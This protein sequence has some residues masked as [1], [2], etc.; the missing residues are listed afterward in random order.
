[1]A[2]VSPVSGSGGGAVPLPPA[3]V[4]SAG[5]SGTPASNAGQCGGATSTTGA[6]Q[7]QNA[8]SLTPAG[9]TQQSGQTGYA[10]SITSSSYSI[11]QSGQDNRLSALV[12]ALVHY[13]LTGKEDEKEKNN[14]FAAL[15]GMALLSSLDQQTG[16]VS[17]YESHSS[18]YSQS[19]STSNASAVQAASYDQASGTATSGPATGGSLDVCG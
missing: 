7:S 8:V 15:I 5:A 4:T 12:M 1:M 19:V 3:N 10:Q 14:P 9:S 18:Q 13:L 2:S 16:N 11:Q 6:G 17:Y